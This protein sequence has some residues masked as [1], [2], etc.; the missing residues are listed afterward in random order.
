[1]IA[2]STRCETAAILFSKYPQKPERPMSES[3]RGPGEPAD[4]ADGFFQRRAGMVAVTFIAAADP[5]RL[6][7]YSSSSYDSSASIS[8]RRASLGL[9]GDQHIVGRLRPAPHPHV[10]DGLC[11][12]SVA[13]S[14]LNV[15]RR[16]SCCCRVTHAMQRTSR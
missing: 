11:H 5:A 2:M 12:R 7:D 13:R 16:S 15:H 10:V 1:M 14:V 9:D 6:C 8:S 4:A 3:Q